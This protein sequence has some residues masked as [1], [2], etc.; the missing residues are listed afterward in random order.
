M[1]SAG[2]P[3]AGTRRGGGNSG[4]SRPRNSPARR[5]AAAPGAR[6]AAA[7]GAR[8]AAA[9]GA[10]KA[11]APGAGRARR[12]AAAPG[13]RKAAAPGAG[14]AA[15][16]TTPRKLVSSADEKYV[17]RFL[18]GVLSDDSA[19]AERFAQGLGVR[20]PAGLDYEKRVNEAFREAAAAAA[21]SRGNYYDDDGYV[22]LSGVME[23]AGEFEK[24]DDP[25]E[26][27]RIYGQIADAI[28][29]NQDL[30]YL[31]GDHHEA[32]LVAIKKWAECLNKSCPE[33]ARLISCIDHAF[34]ML[35]KSYDH[36]SEY[37][38]AL[39]LLC[40][41]NADLRH[42][43]GLTRPH[44][45]APPAAS[46]D[47]NRRGGGLGLDS[48]AAPGSENM[49]SIAAKALDRLG[50]TG[51]ANRLFASHARA[52]PRAC[53]LLV[54][55]LAK[56][57][58]RPLAASA[59]AGGLDRFGADPEIVR[60]AVGIYAKGDSRHR[61]VLSDL[62]VRTADWSY[63]EQLCKM[64]GW[65][66][67][68]ASIVRRIE[69]DAKLLPLLVSMLVREGMHKRAIDAIAASG[70]AD[71]FVRYSASVSAAQP[72]AYLAAY[73]RCIGALA[74]QAATSWQ[75]GRVTLHLRN[76]SQV[77]GGKSASRRLACSLARK[78]P[79]NRRL[80]RT[81]APFLR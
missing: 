77:R 54:R 65:A 45:P 81:L 63:Y 66:R 78:F 37:E 12:P 6:K 36:R 71:M 35:K 53:A 51:S 62:F 22:D 28:T 72:R 18:A 79:G 15:A 60:A 58:R 1:R 70:S 19:L 23:A 75:H 44:V 39:W 33:P 29:N 30:S 76:M 26:A 16:S 61:A 34:K 11:A 3:A 64:P 74:A 9:P 10:R 32:A 57:G 43:L 41:S 69:G 80:A 4:A 13:A 14:R 50:R 49:L 56:A 7:A 42:L 31:D 20:P 24:H 52:S 5:P 55:R 38:E 2:R 47:P 25:G 21:S 48:L 27:S 40:R 8:K 46:P 59:A 73:G 67:E 68:R 17:R